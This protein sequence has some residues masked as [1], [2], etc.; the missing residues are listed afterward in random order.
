MS[1]ILVNLR[2]L[3]ALTFWSMI[4]FSVAADPLTIPQEQ[5]LI[6]N[7]LAAKT[8]MRDPHFQRWV[9]TTAMLYTL[10][11]L[12]QDKTR[13]L[14]KHLYKLSIPENHIKELLHSYPQVTGTYASTEGEVLE[15]TCKMLAEE[16]VHPYCTTGN[17]INDH[18]DS[19]WPISYAVLK[20]TEESRTSFILNCSVASKKIQLP[21]GIQEIKYSAKQIYVFRKDEI[22]DISGQGI[23]AWRWSSKN[24]LLLKATKLPGSNPLIGEVAITTTFWKTPFIWRLVVEP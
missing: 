24:D 15:K 1:T 12:Q 20:S 16:G 4:A 18:R 23:A 22:K 14:K 13:D 17:V 10:D 8:S 9:Y 11:C 7:V 19:S 2:F 3:I 21:S 5:A 6:R